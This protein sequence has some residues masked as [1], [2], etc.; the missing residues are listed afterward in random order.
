MN[1]HYR[2]QV[3]KAAPPVKDEELNKIMNDPRMSAQER[4]IAVRDRAKVMER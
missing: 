1:S 2:G 4:M 3:K